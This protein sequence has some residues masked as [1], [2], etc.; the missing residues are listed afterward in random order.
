[1]SLASWTDSEENGADP[2]DTRVDV[3]DRLASGYNYVTVKAYPP[4]PALQQ[5]PTAGSL[6]RCIMHNDVRLETGKY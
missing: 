4:L 5:L 6:F 2:K 3:M 1:M